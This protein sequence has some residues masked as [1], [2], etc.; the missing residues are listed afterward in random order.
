[1]LLKQLHKFPA[2]N[3]GST[4]NVFIFNTLFTNN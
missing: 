1:M 3:F 2:N 4:K